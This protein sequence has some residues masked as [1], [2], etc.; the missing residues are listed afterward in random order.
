MNMKT[1]T[2]FKQLLAAVLLTVAA[3]IAALSQNGTVLLSR[4]A[5]VRQKVKSNKAGS[6]NTSLTYDA[7]IKTVQDA[8][9]P[10][11]NLEKD[12]IPV[13]SKWEIQQKYFRGGTGVD[14]GGGSDIVAEFVIQGSSLLNRLEV[15]FPKI[16]EVQTLKK[17]LAGKAL[18]I[19][20]V[21]NLID[22]ING[23]SIPNQD[24][25]IAYGLPGLIQLKTKEWDEAFKGNKNM[26]H[27]I[28]HELC[29]AA[30]PECNDEAYRISIIQ[31]GLAPTSYA[32]S[33]AV[34]ARTPQLL[35]KESVEKADIVGMRKA[36]EM[37]FRIN[38]ELRIGSGPSYTSY[39]LLSPLAYAAMLGNDKS[40]EI[41]LKLGADV[42]HHDSF[43]QV[44]LHRAAAFNRVSSI[45]Y[46]VSHGAEIEIAGRM[47][48]PRED[49]WKRTPPGTPNQPTPLMAT[50]RSSALDAAKT[51]IELGAKLDYANESNQG[52]VDQVDSPLGQAVNQENLAFV[53]LFLASGARI[54]QPFWGCW[55]PLTCAA[56]MANLQITLELLK[57]GANPNEMWTDRW[58]TTHAPLM[59]A[60]SL[61]MIKLLVSR[62]ARADYISPEGVTA[63]HNQAFEGN[64]EIL[65]ELIRAGAPLNQVKQKSL[66]YPPMTA[67]DIT[68]TNLNGRVKNEAAFN[69]LRSLGAKRAAEL[70]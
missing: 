19:L 39:E 34:A 42:N 3:P 60:K 28:F 48:W 58:G 38:S 27:H 25:L 62:G 57:F 21:G 68:E 16:S 12:S 35:M 33:V 7:R 8:L 61:P 29:R 15:S 43:D 11:T 53:K 50:I 4:D 6:L 54:N 14:G 56:H 52:T 47:Y 20:P 10:K 5:I 30:A 32:P 41:L 9:N 45:R 55:N 2:Q 65:G 13:K 49:R 17:L 26:D 24:G 18:R 59:Y 22:I 40:L 36:I 46:L 51:L 63:L 23:S 67:L 1:Q 70:D 37:G 31:L 69:F 66:D 64:V 44:A